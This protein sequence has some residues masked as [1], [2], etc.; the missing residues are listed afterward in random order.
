MRS[1]PRVRRCPERDPLGYVADGAPLRTGRHAALR[2]HRRPRRRVLR[3]AGGGHLGAHRAERRRQDDRVQRH[4]APVQ[5]RLRRASTVDGESLLRAARRT[6]S[7][8]RASRA[9]SRTSSS[10]ARCRVLENVLVGAHGRGRKAGE[11]EALEVLDVVGLRE[12]ALL[13][14]CGASVRRS[15]SAS[16]WRVR[17]SRSR[18]SSCWTSR[19]AG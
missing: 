3:R 14:G 8:A 17:S 18:A 15:R 4:H 5:A 19:P 1:T 2:R 10:S 12:R 11:K 6:G 16:S 9:R 13:P 7:C